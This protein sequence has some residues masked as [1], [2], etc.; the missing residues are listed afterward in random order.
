MTTAHDLARRLDEI[1]R[2]LIGPAARVTLVLRPSNRPR[3]P[4]LF[5]EP[6]RRWLAPWGARAVMARATLH[7]LADDASELGRAHGTRARRQS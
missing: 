7:R 1:D 3:E 6:K 4:A 5:P 2:A